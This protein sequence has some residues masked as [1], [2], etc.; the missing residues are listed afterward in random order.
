MAY[1][2][3]FSNPKTSRKDPQYFCDACKE[4]FDFRP[5]WNAHKMTME[6]RRKTYNFQKVL[7]D[8]CKI[9]FSSKAE[10]KEHETL[11]SHRKLKEQ[12]EIRLQEQ[13]KNLPLRSLQDILKENEDLRCLVT[14][15]QNAQNVLFS[16]K[17]LGGHEALV[18]LIIELKS[19]N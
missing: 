7:C 16:P 15:N 14:I 2:E 6:H 11:L 4:G 8:I 9:E 5:D 3:E 10:L 17:I 1:R 18:G 13:E 12:F 19:S